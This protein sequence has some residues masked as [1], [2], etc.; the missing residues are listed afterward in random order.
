M[1]FSIGTLTLIA[2]VESRINKEIFFGHG[3]NI[4]KRATAVRRKLGTR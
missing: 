4:Q 3:T 1:K 2:L